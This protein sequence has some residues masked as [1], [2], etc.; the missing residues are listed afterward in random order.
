M[1]FR[2]PWHFRPW[3]TMPGT[4]VKYHSEKY[5]G[6][7]YVVLPWYFL[8][9]GTKCGRKPI[10]RF[11]NQGRRHI[12]KGG[13]TKNF[14]CTLIGGTKSPSLS[15]QFAAMKATKLLHNAHCLIPTCFNCS[16]HVQSIQSCKI[17]SK[18]SSICVVCKQF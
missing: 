9:R 18:T 2:S 6:T 11:T 15:P 1:L 16:F 17:L 7:F 3:Y 5:H 10:S 8:T 14:E 4:M 13:G 12:F